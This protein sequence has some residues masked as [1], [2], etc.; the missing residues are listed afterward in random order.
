MFFRVFADTVVINFISAVVI[1][2]RT[3]AAVGDFGGLAVDAVEVKPF[4]PR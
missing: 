3:A 1:A 4:D 2:P